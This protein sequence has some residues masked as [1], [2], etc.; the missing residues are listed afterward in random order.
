VGEADIQIMT[1]EPCPTTTTIDRIG[2]HTEAA[3]EVEATAVIRTIIGEEATGAVAAV[4]EAE[5][6]G[7]AEIEEATPIAPTTETTGAILGVDIEGIIM[8]IVATKG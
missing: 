2:D 8:T 6:E 5:T 4:S 3:I 1:T 7:A